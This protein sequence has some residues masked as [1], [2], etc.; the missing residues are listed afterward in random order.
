MLVFAAVAAAALLQGP[1]A[2]APL[3]PNAFDSTSA[4]RDTLRPRD[5]TSKVNSDSTRQ[6]R[7][8]RLARRVEVTPELERTAFADPL[9]RE[10]LLKARV[11]RMRNDSSIRAY[12]A[13]VYQRMSVGMGFKAIARER[14]AMRV[15]NAAHIRW[16]KD[17][18][19][20]MEITGSRA[21][22]PM[23]GGM[24][25][26]KEA[27]SE[28]NKEMHE[29]APIPWYPGKEALWVGGDGGLARANVDEADIVHPL[30]TGAEAYYKYQT[31]DSITIALSPE[32]RIRLR[33]LRITAREPKWNLVVGSFWFDVSGGQLVRAVYRMS[34]PMDPWQVAKENADS[35]DLKDMDEIP[36]LVKPL[37]FPMQAEIQSIA[38]E[39]GLFN[40]VWMPRV[41]AIEAYARASFMRFPFTMEER[42]TYASVNVSDEPM[43][44]ITRAARPRTARDSA[45]VGDSLR[46]EGV[47][48]R[49]SIG[50]D[51]ARTS[52][53]R[54]DS[55]GRRRTRA[56]IKAIADS[57]RNEPDSVRKAR[58]AARVERDS[59]RARARR[60]ECD[61]TGFVTTTELRYEGTLPVAVRMPCDTM[62][63]LASKELPPSIY[64]PGEE[65][66]GAAEREELV[67]SLGLGLQPGWAPRAVEWHYGLA[68]GVVRYNRVEG[69]SAGVGVRQTLGDGYSWTASA[70]Y[71]VG[72]AT[73][74]GELGVERSNGRRALGLSAY[75]RT[76]V[77]SDWGQP[78]GFGA[79]TAALLYAHDEAFYFRSTGAEV[80][81]RTEPQ[82]DLELR[83]FVE[84]QDS[85]PVVTR[86]SVFGGS[87]DARFVPNLQARSGTV[88]GVEGRLRR[89]YGLDPN[90]WRFSF[91]SRGE[92]GGGDWLYQRA[93]IDMVVSRHVVGPFAASVSAGGGAAFGDVPAQRYF[94]L[95][96]LHTVRGQSP[97]TPPDRGGIAG[98]AGGSAY[99]L[100]RSELAYGAPA[101]RVA[102]FYDAGWTGRKRDWQQ[103]GR[104]LS[105]AGVGFS[106]LDGLMRLDI[107]R[108]IFPTV[109]W[110]TDFSVEARF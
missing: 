51:G 55:A 42:Y 26:M 73:A 80:T 89:Q 13:T 74:L 67:K 21:V 5:V 81:W 64:D 29:M 75:R 102:A 34:V 94:Y 8:R 79:A 9:A 17:V 86:Y 66:F 78:F 38:V 20:W 36:T 48:V 110:R 72:E 10:L 11:A 52:V 15:E 60:A 107:A 69:F 49:I 59:A 39:Y 44:L 62:K 109:Q 96:G 7:R 108:G 41:Q 99:W 98:S 30:A 70:R 54:T 95:G 103:P 105:G 19:I 57:I 37:I 25:G 12:D 90:G 88:A 2:P 104:P 18:G 92:L 35:S 82:R 32:R 101:F 56:E 45:A 14:L 65:L 91:D 23:L 100:T 58:R 76:A 63:L 93:A 87:N 97:G 68:E 27:E 50:S 40:G 84:R 33:E 53:T 24:P 43:P 28:M 1:A 3:R 6:G 106:M 4:R 31:G 22:M 61:A 71:N 83:G 85:M 47:D 77:A 46:R 16:N